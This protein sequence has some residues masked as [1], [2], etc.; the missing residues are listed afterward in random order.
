MKKYVVYSIIFH[1]FIVTLAFLFPSHQRNI[2]T[3]QSFY[4]RL[5]APEEINKIKA[6]EKPKPSIKQEP[7]KKQRELQPM[8]LLKNTKQS[9]FT[10]PPQLPRSLPAPKDMS[11]HPFVP[12]TEEI[13]LP[14]KN[15]TRRQKQA[16][17]NITANETKLKGDTQDEDKTKGFS[18]DEKDF[19][20][21][22]SD[23]AKLTDESKISK[24]SIKT[25]REKLFD[26]DVINNMAKTGKEDKNLSSGLTINTSHYKYYGYAYMTA[27][28]IVNAWEDPPDYVKGGIGGATWIKYTIKK[29][30]SLES[31]ELLRT[32]GFKSLDDYAIKAL[33]D[34]EPFWPLPTSWGEDTYTGTFIFYY[35]PH[36]EPG[37]SQHFILVP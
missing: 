28:K 20:G 6:I 26:R 11:S 19:Q 8:P 15:D 17:D 4:A 33:K 10:I 18:L 5:V 22:N 36:A 9:V 35:L 29:N 27:I 32:S 7:I 14:K 13:T 37:H 34:S 1:I 3:P 2:K 31:V 12:N 23:S 16:L 25:L 24:Q 30:G 21:K